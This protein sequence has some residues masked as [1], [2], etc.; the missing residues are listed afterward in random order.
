MIWILIE[1]NEKKKDIKYMGAKNYD[2]L[3]KYINTYNTK[4]ISD[5][6]FI[7][8][9]KEFVIHMCEMLDWR[10]NNDKYQ[11]SKKTRYLQTKKG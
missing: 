5:Y 9:K 7:S 11:K 10:E 6:Y 8:D 4:K 1:I 2:T 3:I